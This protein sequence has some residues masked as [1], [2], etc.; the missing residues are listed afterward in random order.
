MQLSLRV[1]LAVLLALVSGLCAVIALDA[2][3]TST[4]QPDFGPVVDWSVF[5]IGLAGGAYL[6]LSQHPWPRRLTV[7][8]AATAAFAVLFFFTTDWHARADGRDW[9]CWS[10]APQSA[11]LRTSAASGIRRVPPGIRCESVSGS[12]VIRPDT[13]DWFV[14][15]GESAAAGF[16]AT[17][18]LLW[19]IGTI[20]RRRRFVTVAPKPG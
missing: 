18:P 15:L 4:Y 19:L 2:R 13:K 20:T 17:G 1:L 3:V 7:F 8:T 9:E 5:L 6:A 14:L 10:G 11:D 16:A 12:Y